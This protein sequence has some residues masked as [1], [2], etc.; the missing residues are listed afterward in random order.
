M[1]ANNTT[2]TQERMTRDFDKQKICCYGS[3]YLL[4]AETGA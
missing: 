1:A 4:H 2:G 3:I